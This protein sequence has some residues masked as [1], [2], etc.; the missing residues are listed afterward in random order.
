MSERTDVARAFEELVRDVQVD[1]DLKGRVERRL[2]RR[3][4]QRWGRSAAAAVVAL[5]SLAVV[6]STVRG[7]D[8]DQWVS[9][10]GRDGTGADGDLAERGPVSVVLDGVH[11][12]ERWRVEAYSSASGLCVDLRYEGDAVG[13]CGLDEVNRAVGVV[14]GRR[15][16]VEAVFGT[17]R[18]DVAT[19]DVIRASRETLSFAPV[20]GN[21]GFEQ[22][23]YA[24]IV[25]TTDPIITVVARDAGG[26]E[27]DRHFV[28]AWEGQLVIDFED[29]TI[30]APAF[31]RFVDE[32]QPE[33][34]RTPR[35]SAEALISQAAQGEIQISEE[36][37]DTV[38][39][40]AIGLEDDSVEAVRYELHFTRG[41]DELYRFAGGAWSQR[42]RPGRGHDEAFLVEPCV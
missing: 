10:D 39:V 21:P 30:E 41:D 37:N 34:A 1:P 20:T 18:S 7:E 31:N 15:N 27:V 42:C 3:R 29:G 32:Q 11:E 5:G 28:P 22:G 40:T 4:A 23:F 13:G 19:I 25:D 8:G 38:V 24:F 2:R 14:R 17:A 33:W 6:V 16:G 36:G 26:R 9:A 12:G 35:G